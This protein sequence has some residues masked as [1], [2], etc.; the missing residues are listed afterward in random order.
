MCSLL[1]LVMYPKHA[2]SI[3]QPLPADYWG[4]RCRTSLNRFITTTRVVSH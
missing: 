2:H 3:P 4:P 1:S